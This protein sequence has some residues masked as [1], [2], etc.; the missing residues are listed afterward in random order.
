MYSRILYNR[1]IDSSPSARLS[2]PAN[3]ELISSF[4][5]TASSDMLEQ[6]S[7][8]YR[9]RI[10]QR[11]VVDRFTFAAAKIVNNNLFA[12]CF[13]LLDAVAATLLEDE[14]AAAVAESG[15]AADGSE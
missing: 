12:V 4:A 14:A 8:S 5:V 15:G 13:F 6:A 11:N 3:G 10:H 7:I 2:E 1:T 9:I